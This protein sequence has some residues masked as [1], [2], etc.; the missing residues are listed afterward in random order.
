MDLKR[1]DGL[2]PE[3]AALPVLAKSLNTPFV[4]LHVDDSE[5]DRIILQTACAKAKV[6]FEWRIAE[7]ATQAIA[8]LEALTRS[9]QPRAGGWPDLV[10]LDIIMP[11]GSGLK[12]L[13]YIRSTLALKK[14]L[15]VVLTGSTDP[16]FLDKA[17]D[18]GVNSYLE[19]PL[20]FGDMAELMTLIYK[21]WTTARRPTH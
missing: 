7:N 13:E 8:Y 2:A 20:A 9:G 18:L 6:P 14:M 3:P 4:V 11:G 19:K 12:V 16:A 17:R 21:M 5:D 1:H 15:V 10:V